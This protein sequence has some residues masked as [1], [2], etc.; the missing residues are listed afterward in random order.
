VP[1]TRPGSN[2]TIPLGGGLYASAVVASSTRTPY[3]KYGWTGVIRD[4]SQIH[5]R[6]PHRGHARFSA[7]NCAQSHALLMATRVPRRGVAQPR[8]SDLEA[9]GKRSAIT[10]LTEQIWQ[11]LVAANGGSCYYCGCKPRLLVRE[12]RVPLSRGGTNDISNIVPACP[13]CNRAKGSLTEAEYGGLLR[14]LGYRKMNER[15]PGLLRRVLGHL[16]RRR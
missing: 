11:E 5:W 16:R 4:K 2:R 9:V 14:R 10:G 8:R 7:I 3:R 13:E 1:R 6:C 15:P 12:H